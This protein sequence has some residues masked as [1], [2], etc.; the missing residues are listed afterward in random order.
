MKIGDKVTRR[1]RPALG[2][3][4][5]IHLMGDTVGVK[6]PRDGIPRMEFEEK[7]YSLLLVFLRCLL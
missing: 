2:E 4:E 3:G 5:I 6:G 7:K 1:W